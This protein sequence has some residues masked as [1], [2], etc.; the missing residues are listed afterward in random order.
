MDPQKDDWREI[1]ED[2]EIWLKNFKRS[3]SSRR[4]KCMLCPNKKVPFTSFNKYVLKRHY[5]SFHPE[6]GKEFNVQ[7][8][9]RRNESDQEPTVSKKVKSNVL[10]KG[11]YIKNCVVLAVVHMTSFA[12]FN[13]APFQELTSIHSTN[14]QLLINSANIGIFIALTAK[15]IRRLIKEELGR[16]IFSVKLDIATRHRRSMLGVNIQFYCSLRQKIVIHTLGFIELASHTS[17]YLQQE[18][19]KLLDS[20]EINRRNIYC[21]ISDN[22]AN[23]FR[24]GST[25]LLMQ[26][27][28]NL[29]H[30]MRQEDSADESDGDE[31]T[32]FN[33]DF[34]ENSTQIDE[35]FRN[36]QDFYGD[37]TMEIPVVVRCAAQTLQLVVHDA[38]KMI[39]KD[40]IQSI[41]KVIM[42]LRSSEG[43]DYMNSTLKALKFHFVTRWNS[44][45]LMFLSI[46]KNKLHF[47]EMYRRIPE[48]LK[49]HI[50]LN[51]AQFKFMEQFTEAFAPIIQFSNELQAEQLAMS[52]LIFFK[53]YVF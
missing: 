2:D 7:I 5:V 43:F 40:N 46:L 23:M 38:L 4:I 39:G 45:H 29:T 34:D 24:L 1:T 33:F 18:V 20:Y 42:E 37:G 44:L 3:D 31:E 17:K 10:T 28:L 51:V 15:Y 9:R 49:K 52:K 36:E 47:E 26:H 22:G 35:A 50:F 48:S 27:D 13:A 8:K 21:F 11:E 19:Y 12:I 41:R 30:E 32:E 16:K 14:A 53:Y 6:H 25:S